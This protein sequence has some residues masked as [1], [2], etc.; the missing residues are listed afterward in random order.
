MQG[1]D[2]PERR[3]GQNPGLAW[4]GKGGGTQSGWLECR[5]VWTAMGGKVGA[6]VSRALSGS[7]RRLSVSRGQQGARDSSVTTGVGFRA[8]L[9]KN[10]SAVHF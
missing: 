4:L 5:S 8:W 7:L 1:K 6:R 9:C 2:T 10:E 3:N